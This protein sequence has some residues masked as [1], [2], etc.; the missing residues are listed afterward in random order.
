MKNDVITFMG[1][2]ITVRVKNINFWIPIV[3][4]VVAMFAAYFGINA[5]ELNSY[6]DVFD[7]LLKGV[8]DPVLMVSVLGYIW[9]AVV[10]PTTKGFSDSKNALE[11]K[12][13]KVD[14]N[15]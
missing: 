12:T 8:K 6:Q 11:Y 13:P 5:S 9:N 2:N 15:R 7:V 10:D 3:G 14:D 1:V 4:S